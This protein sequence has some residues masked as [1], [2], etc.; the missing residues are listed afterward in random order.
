MTSRFSFTGICPALK[1][2]LGNTVLHKL[3]FLRTFE[4][5]I[6]WLNSGRIGNGNKPVNVK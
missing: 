6:V 1:L 5:G 4:I 3:A 2:H